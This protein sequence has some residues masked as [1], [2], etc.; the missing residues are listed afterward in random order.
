[1]DDYYY[2][3][4]YCTDTRENACSK[5]FRGVKKYL[6]KGLL[7][8]GMRHNQASYWAALTLELSL[9]L[10]PIASNKIS[11]TFIFMFIFCYLCMVYAQW[12]QCVDSTRFDEQ[13][14]LFIYQVW[15]SGKICKNVLT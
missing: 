6:Q 11:H 2:Y 8:S 12:N 14:S 10:F 1:M 4:K 13:K 9:T 3:V 15:F 5:L 7:K